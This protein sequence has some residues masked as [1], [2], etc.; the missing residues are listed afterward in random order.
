MERGFLNQKGVGGR[1]VKE[2]QHG[3]A[4]DVAK[5]TFNVEFFV[6][7]VSMAMNLGSND[8]NMASVNLEKRKYFKFMMLR[9]MHSS[10][11]IETENENLREEVKRIS[12][13]SKDVQENLLK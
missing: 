13:E 1:G 7:D 12:K 2:K 5:D 6:V 9:I 10:V 8:V 3:S 11:E 4:N